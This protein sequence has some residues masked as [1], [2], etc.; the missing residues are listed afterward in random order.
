MRV[1]TILFRHNI[2][3]ILYFKLFCTI[4]HRKHS[5]HIWN[6]H[7]IDSLIICP[8]M[9]QTL[10][11]FGWYVLALWYENIPMITSVWA[12]I[13]FPIQL[14]IEVMDHTVKLPGC[15]F[16]EHTTCFLFEVIL[17]IDSSRCICIYRAVRMRYYNIFD[18]NLLT[19]HF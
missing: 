5:F 9:D 14:L 4:H 16:Q 19:T 1:G 17:A 11:W 12:S 15:N 10:T 18:L 3:Q 2:Q 8:Y 13:E 7:T 6:H